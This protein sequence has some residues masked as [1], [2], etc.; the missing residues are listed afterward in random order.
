MPV[1]PL[2]PDEKP[3]TPAAPAPKPLEIQITIGTAPP[4]P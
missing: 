2:R 3:P 1:R 4:K